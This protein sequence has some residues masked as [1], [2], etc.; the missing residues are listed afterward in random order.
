MKT[1]SNS[2]K[3]KQNKI[4]IGFVG[5][6]C[7][8]KGVAAAY[9]QKKY[10][11]D[12][13]MFSTSMRDILDRLYLPQSREN[14]QKISLLLRDNFGSDIFSKTMVS[15][16]AKG[17]K[18]FVVIDGFRRVEDV[19]SFRSLPSFTLIH[20]TAPEKVRYERL[21]AR[22]QNPGDA[23]VTWEQF[24]IQDNAETEKTIAKAAK[25]ADIHIDNSLSLKDLY[26][27]LDEVVTKA[28]KK[29]SS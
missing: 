10:R 18:Q 28:K 27:K 4:V 6:I 29:R 26:K 13:A 2:Q 1:K 11:A 20:M 9:L 7:S 5:K 25:Q 21:R 22:K 16:I 23:K 12:S 3:K 15:D 8:G 19:L 14:L 24:R 17:K